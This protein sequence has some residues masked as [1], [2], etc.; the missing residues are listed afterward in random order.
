MNQKSGSQRLYKILLVEDNSDDV[1]LIQR[2]LK[3][4][5]APIELHAASD[6]LDALSFLRCEPP[7]ADAPRPDLILLDLNMPRMNGHQ[8]LVELKRDDQLKVIPTVILS[9]SAFEPDVYG[10]YRE[11]ASAYLTKPFYI[12]EHPERT[13]CFLDFWL[14]DVAILPPVAAKPFTARTSLEHASE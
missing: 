3:R 4:M 13:K 8:F 1:W 14:G 7:Y 9:T 5:S 12:H 11:H 2:A 6:G 10:A